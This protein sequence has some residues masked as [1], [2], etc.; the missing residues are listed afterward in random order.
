MMFTNGQ[1]K[2]TLKRKASTDEWVVVWYD[3]SVRKGWIRNEE[4]CY[5]TGDKEDAQGTMRITWQ[6]YLALGV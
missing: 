2:L 5:Y 6:R 4:K 3:M 1:V